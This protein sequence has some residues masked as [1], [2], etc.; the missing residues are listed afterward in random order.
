MRQSFFALA[1]AVLALAACSE[2]PQTSTPP[3]PA[4]TKTP[5]A[6]T[7]TASGKTRIALLLPLSGRAAPIG[8]SLQQAAEM[9]LFDTG[10]KE[11]ALAS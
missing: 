3:P 8:P 9:A 11:L 4:T 10:A 1:A 2:S 7:V 6:S 5:V